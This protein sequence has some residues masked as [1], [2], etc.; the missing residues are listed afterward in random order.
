L[1]EQQLKN[2]LKEH[3][4][5]TE[6]QLKNETTHLK[7][8]TIEKVCSLLISSAS[9]LMEIA[10][11]NIFNVYFHSQIHEKLSIIQS[12]YTKLITAALI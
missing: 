3:H 9:L 10:K 8:N 5:G 7:P 12:T 2:K 11:K 6:R 1:K 4:L